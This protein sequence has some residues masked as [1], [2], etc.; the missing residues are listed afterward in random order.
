MAEQYH[1]VVALH[2]NHHGHGAGVYGAGRC[3]RT[4]F[5]I[6]AVVLHLHFGVFAVALAAECGHDVGF[7]VE[8][9]GQFAL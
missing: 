4:G 6:D 2:H 8:R 1:I 3:A 9:Q 5:K 7:A